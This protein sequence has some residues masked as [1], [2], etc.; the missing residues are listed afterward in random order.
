MRHL[1]ALC[2]LSVMA[3]CGDLGCSRDVTETV[4]AWCAF[5]QCGYECPA[6][7]GDVASV[8]QATGTLRLD[9]GHLSD[10][11]TDACAPIDLSR[12]FPT[13]H[14][15]V[16]IDKINDQLDNL[17]ATVDAQSIVRDASRPMP[18]AERRFLTKAR[19][20]APSWAPTLSG[21]VSSMTIP[22]HCH[23][24]APPNPF[25]E[26]RVECDYGDAGWN[27]QVNFKRL[28]GGAR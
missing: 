18:S 23:E 28:D 1:V 27:L 7:P 12:T 8:G 13:P 2:L 9:D 15:Q 24:V 17:K 21:D 5:A 25:G 19:S 6:C 26:G 11:A 16:L 14:Q 3:S 22:T 4:G 20:Q 10:A